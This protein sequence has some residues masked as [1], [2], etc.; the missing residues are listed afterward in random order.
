M[1]SIGD[2]EGGHLKLMGLPDPAADPDCRIVED[3]WAE[4][5]LEQVG[6]ARD[7]AKKREM[8]REIAATAAVSAKHRKKALE[9]IADLEK[10]P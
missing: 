2:F 8:L 10:K 4:W 5:K 7:P 3:A 1:V 9:M 6:E